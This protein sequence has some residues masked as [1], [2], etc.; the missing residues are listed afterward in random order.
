MGVIQRYGIKYP[1]TSDNEE[2]MFLDVNNSEAECIKSKLLHVIFTPKG[3][4]IR[5]PEFGTNLIQFIFSQ[6]DSNT[7]SDIRKEI[8]DCVS[9]YVPEVIFKN[10]NV[11][12]EDEEKSIVVTIDYDA[13]IGNKV[14][15]TTVGVKL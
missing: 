2:K 10:I 7:M 1:F 6:N 15:S 8:S 9:K 14:E 12:K 4:K 3:Q 5:D 13:K 11:Y